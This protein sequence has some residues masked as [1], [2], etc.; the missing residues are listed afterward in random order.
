[1]FY[2]LKREK[3]TLKLKRLLKNKFQFENGLQLTLSSEIIQKYNLRKRE[4]LAQEEYEK[5]LELAALSTSY[6]YLTKRDYSKKELYYKLL[7]KYRE[8]KI[9]NSVIKILEEKGYLDDYEFASNF[10]KIKNSS[11]KKLE[12][13]LKLKGIE[14]WII[15]EVM[16]EY[17]SEKEI[18]VLKKELEK[19]RGRDE[20]KQIES[21]MR[22]GFKYSDIVKVIKEK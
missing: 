20:K 12:F 21:L 19:V 15:N 4:E 11:K 22:K 17:E 1:M 16:S 3:R 6:Y 10:V 18:E 2:R 8:K 5:V 13:E 7:E 14:S 9:V